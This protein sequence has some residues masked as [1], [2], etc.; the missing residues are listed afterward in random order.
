MR[1]DGGG[2]GFSFPVTPTEEV[3]S[4]H[5]EKAERVFSTW[6]SS[7]SRASLAEEEGG[8]PLPLSTLLLPL[9]LSSLPLP[10]SG[11]AGWR[12]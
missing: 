5:V 7:H 3:E 10:H 9:P 4:E 1:R 8:A 11:M 6:A 2:F 12:G